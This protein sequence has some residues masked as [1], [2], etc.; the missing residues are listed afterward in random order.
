[1]SGDMDGFVCILHIMC[2]RNIDFVAFATK[3]YYKEVNAPFYYCCY[4]NP[5]I[6][7]LKYLS[8]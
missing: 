5:S 8:R 3:F 4:I 1:M 7:T 2:L 6:Q